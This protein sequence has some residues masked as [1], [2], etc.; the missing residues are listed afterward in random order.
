MGID[1]RLGDMRDF[2]IEGSFDRIISPY[3]GL[4]CLLE[5]TALAKC[6]ERV[7]AHLS[8][9]GEFWFDGYS[10]ESLHKDFDRSEAETASVEFVGVVEFEGRT[11]DVLERGTWDPARQLVHAHYEHIPRDR[12]AVITTEL[13]Q[14]YLRPEELPQL[15]AQGGLR[16]KRMYGGF[17]GS[18]FSAE[19]DQLVVCATRV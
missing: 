12:S 9:I 17:D 5:E 3:N 4:Y 2:S 1:A 18:A 19:S 6:F 14:R 8:D 15:L 11:Y 10:V 13:P 16:L 7:A